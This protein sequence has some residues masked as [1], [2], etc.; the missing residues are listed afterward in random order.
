MSHDRL[1]KSGDGLAADNNPLNAARRSP[2][3]K[4]NDDALFASPAE[5]EHGDT[6]Y[7]MPDE[8]G[9]KGNQSRGVGMVRDSSGGK[10][11]PRKKSVILDEEDESD[12]ETEGAK[13]EERKSRK[14]VRS[15][16]VD[17]AGAIDT[18]DRPRS[19][20]PLDTRS[21]S[22]R[23]RTP[24]AKRFP[25]D[26]QRSHTSRP[27]TTQ[28]ST[29]TS[30]QRVPQVPPT[31]ATA[32]TTTTADIR[33]QARERERRH[34]RDR[35]YMRFV[36]G[37]GLSSG[38]TLAATTTT[39]LEQ[40]A[41]YTNERR[42]RP[43]SRS[44]GDTEG[45]LEYFGGR[46]G[47]GPGGRQGEA[48]AEA[49]AA[50]RV[51]RA[52]QERL[53]PSVG[54]PQAK[55]LPHFSL[56]TKFSLG[57]ASGGV[58]L[59][60]RHEFSRFVSPLGSGSCGGGEASEGE[61][62]LDEVEFDLGLGKDLDYT[63]AEAMKVAHQQVNKSKGDANNKPEVVTNVD[64]RRAS[65]GAGIPPA[66]VVKDMPELPLPAEAAQLLSEARQ[67][68]VN[69]RVIPK[70]KTGRKAS[71]GMG[72]FKE[73]AEAKATDRE[74]GDAGKTRTPV[75]EEENPYEVRGRDGIDAGALHDRSQHQSPEAT[76]APTVRPKLR[77][78]GS[79][80][81]DQARR[82]ASGS[83]TPTRERDR[84]RMLGHHLAG[85]ARTAQQ[86][87][88]EP[89]PTHR[90]FGVS[91]ALSRHASRAASPTVFNA[92]PDH[93]EWSS[94]GWWETSSG[95]SS[96]S[97]NE[98]AEHEEEYFA[99]QP[100]RDVPHR[101]GD[102][103]A[104]RRGRA[105]EH[106]DLLDET[107]E[108]A[109]DSI[110]G[111]HRQAGGEM[112]IPLQPFNNKVGGHSEIY[113]FT[114]RA[115]CKPLVSRENLFYES[116]EK[117]APALLGYI[118]RYLGVML[119]NYR[120]QSTTS[121]NTDVVE[122]E[123]DKPP[124]GNTSKDSPKDGRGTMTP[125]A[126]QDPASPHSPPSR[127][128]MRIPARSQ[129]FNIAQAQ[130]QH[131]SLE[132]QHHH[133]IP[134]VALRNN[135]HVVPD[136]LFARGGR[137]TKKDLDKYKNWQT[138]TDAEPGANSPRKSRSMERRRSHK[139]APDS[140]FPST[141]SP[142]SASNSVDS[143]LQP[144]PG[145]PSSIAL[146]SYSPS[147]P[148]KSFG[149]PQLH[150]ST[151]TPS[152]HG[153]S[154][155]AT[156]M[157]NNARCPTQQLF[158]GTGSTTV[159][160]K[161]KDH[162]FSTILKRMQK[163][164]SRPRS[165]RS[166]RAGSVEREGES[167]DQDQE[168]EIGPLPPSQRYVRRGRLSRKVSGS[169]DM[170]PTH[171]SADDEESF[172][173]IKRIS[174]EVIMSELTRMTLEDSNGSVPSPSGPR[175]VS[176]ER[177]L[178]SMD[179]S[180]S[181]CEEI[182]THSQFTPERSD[183]PSPEED[184]GESSLDDNITRQEYFIFM[185]DLTG[186]LKHPCVLDLKMG[187]RQYGCDATP[188]K[189]KSQRKKCDRT[190][191]RTLGTRVCGMQVW[192]NV[193]QEFVSQNKYTGREIKREEFGDVLASY[194][195]DGRRLL[196]EHI[197]AVI[198]RLHRL[199][200]IIARLKSFRF[201]GC[202]VLLIYDGDQETQDQYLATKRSGMRRNAEE[203]NAYN[204]RLES[205]SRKELGAGRRSRSADAH[206]ANRISEHIESSI[207]K[208]E[209]KIRI[210]DFAHPTT[211]Q[212]F[213]PPIPDEDTSDLGKGYDGKNDP[214]T[215]MPHA[216]FPPKHPN[217]PDLGFLF[218]LQSI[219]ESLTEIY[220]AER[221][222]RVNEGTDHLPPLNT[223]PDENIFQEVFGHSFDVTYLST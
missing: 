54:M 65:F 182:D 188:L 2:L 51:F 155:L 154:H 205:R 13:D 83:M 63:I 181:H 81:S 11:R 169:M 103:S 36:P 158:E 1:N 128:G 214:V 206:N 100:R 9:S 27:S 26:R 117:L 99:R 85:P 17:L 5:S 220:Q 168:D 53:G 186:R 119:V 167:T 120:R 86:D 173:S 97:E 79:G 24:T 12:G 88:A 189:K 68:V 174:S 113:K 73:T 15:S 10:A 161:L 137:M 23:P 175:D 95:V 87:L 14:D 3:Q 165:R 32:T 75:I 191:S 156:A 213:L 221:E 185:E 47:A 121:N 108:H 152:L 18:P 104:E 207:K 107:A 204:L 59:G 31:T 194:F 25:R 140:D 39:T 41:E 143:V 64:E 177:G 145:S 4:A 150:H 90:K 8:V 148:A 118:P 171:E 50:A 98:D 55:A 76:S 215:G 147:S 211:G 192:D 71:M 21:F 42:S 218:G 92:E 66:A 72:L 223:C 159:H 91:P 112:T 199:A 187:T 70:A 111:R 170:T 131:S 114:R 56:D 138:G 7:P 200:A 43:R 35:A 141:F 149:P 110:E 202:S 142:L 44:L 212:D 62:P 217:E 193:K 153:R 48:E 219:T 124:P 78:M 109:V 19:S 115:V 216:R 176:T 80:A 116:V 58:K 203:Q 122:S 197:P 33:Q 222:K 157:S 190:T 105:H 139:R 151:S 125:V 178:F 20:P 198:H 28:P 46:A 208:A 144:P 6:R 22:I 49:E 133:E 84:T 164:S 40:D 195:W 183:S 134:E 93:H 45:Q 179:E 30:S 106:V 77:G 172:Q 96:E 201:Y 146:R 129:S 16:P 52:A 34:V 74:R 135:K 127:P 57:P 196:A 38:A 160:T 130:R 37:L 136:W 61:T 102:H 60:A 209:V 210:V 89:I 82:P 184:D 163:G 101:A 94:D 123:L 69:S 180:A 29:R 162:I 166:L 126:D 67:A 132:N